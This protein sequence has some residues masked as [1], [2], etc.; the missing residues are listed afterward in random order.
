MPVPRRRRSKGVVS[1]SKL[2]SHAL[3]L[4]DVTFIFEKTKPLIYYG[5]APAV[6]LIGLYTEPKPSL[7]DLF[8]IWE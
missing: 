1:L 7:I 5:F 3:S 4:L 6:V 8:N 2:P